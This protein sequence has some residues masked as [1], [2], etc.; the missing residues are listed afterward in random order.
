MFVLLV[1]GAAL[2][3][4]GLLGPTS[5][6]F[7]SSDGEWA[8][9]EVLMKGRDFEAV[10][11]RFQLYRSKCNASAL[12]QRTTRK[13]HWFTVEHWFNDYSEPKWLVP[14]A[15][16]LPKATPG[17]YPPVSATHCANQGATWEEFSQA[18]DRAR[19]LIAD[20][21]NKALQRTLEDS[22]R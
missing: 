17:Y 19:D 12:L 15:D 13:P 3:S 14:Y 7:Q 21:P 11:V 5:V 4:F 6:S 20:L 18:E 9:G 8:D 16:A 2:W 10:V 1:T 22:R